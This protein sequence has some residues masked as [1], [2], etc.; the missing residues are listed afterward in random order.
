MPI[1]EFKCQKCETTTETIFTLKQK[2][3]AIV[4]PK[5]T[6]VADS[7]ISVSRFEVNGSNAANGYAG[8]SN[9]RWFNGGGS[10]D[11]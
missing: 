8:D 6:E 4:C 1:Y 9:Y 7:I 10:S 5:C 2:P 3:E 11:R